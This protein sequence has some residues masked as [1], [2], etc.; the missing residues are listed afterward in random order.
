MDILIAKGMKNFRVPI[1]MERIVPPPSMTGA[2]KTVG[3][4]SYKVLHLVDR[5]RLLPL[6]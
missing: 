3:F 6:Q 5:A 2:I 4:P 1:L